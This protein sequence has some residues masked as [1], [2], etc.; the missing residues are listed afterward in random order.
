MPGKTMRENDFDFDIAHTCSANE[1]TG[2]VSA[3]PV[4]EA[5]WEAYK[6]IYDFGLPRADQ[7]LLD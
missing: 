6:D 3:S 4:T 5:E 2:L 7:K 1:C